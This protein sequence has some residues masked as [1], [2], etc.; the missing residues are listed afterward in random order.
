MLDD[1]TGRPKNGF[2]W[3]FVAADD[4]GG[5]DGA[6]RFAADRSGQ[7]P[8]DILGG[9]SGFLLVD[10]FSGY[11]SIA[12]VSSRVRAECHA[13]LRRYFHESLSTSPAAQEAIELIISLYRVEHEAQRL[14]IVGSDSH[15]EFR[16][17]RSAPARD[18]LKACLDDDLERNRPAM[19]VVPG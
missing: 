15:L 16:K 11:N 5:L 19:D 4:I 9:T 17:Q 2:I 18:R 13:H 10:G 1:G 8:R 12:D 7:T 14:G 6:Y 3:T